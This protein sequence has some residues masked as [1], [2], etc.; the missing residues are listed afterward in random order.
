MKEISIADINA[1]KG[2]GSSMRYILRYFIEKGAKVYLAYEDVQKT[3]ERYFIVKYE[4]LVIPLR[5]CRLNFYSI[6]D[7]FLAQT[8]TTDKF[9]SFAMLAAWQIPTPDTVLYESRERAITF[10]KNH[11][12]CVV[13]PRDGEHGNGITVGVKDSRRLQAAV[14]EAKSVFPQVLLQQKVNGDDFR[15]LFIDYKFVAAVRRDPASI[16]GDG[17]HSIRQLVDSYNENIHSI[18]EG[19]R[20]GEVDSDTIKGSISKIPLEEI[21]NARSAALLDYVPQENEVVSLL[22]KANVSLGGQ[23]T[24]VT[25]QVNLELIEHITRLLKAIG[26]PLC[27]I[28]VLSEDIGSQL[29]EK[30]SYVIELNAAPGLRLH[31][32]PTQG[33]ERR[34]CGMVAESLIR[35]YAAF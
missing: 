15:L 19:I 8:I 4:K 6:H 22:D 32:L 25:E 14:S 26:L 16:K 7:S 35:H 18:W 1:M 11:G 5:A 28:D 3:T 17:E 33:Q 21:V 24:D 13:K 34:V 23:T 9:K 2:N 27:G 10:M 29:S 31:E 12:E 20:G 30:K